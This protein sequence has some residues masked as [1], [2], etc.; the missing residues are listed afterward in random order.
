MKT[1]NDLARRFEE[2]ANSI[3][4]NVEKAQQETAQRI[5][6]DV[7]DNAPLKTGEYVSSIQ[8][9]PTENNGHEISTFIGS[10]LTVG[11]AKSNGKSYNLGYLLENGTLPHD[12][13]PV[14]SN[15]LVFEIEGKKIFAK[16]VY[17]PGTTAQ[18]HYALALEK[19]K[20]LFKDNIK[21]AWRQK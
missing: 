4:E 17:H 19:N 3:D 21:V 2:W 20:E 8:V 9:Y 10:D 6:E 15:Y 18:P 1:L 13:Y 7:V 14:D 11:P 16:H 12:I 5:W